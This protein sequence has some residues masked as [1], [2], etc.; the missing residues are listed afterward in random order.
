MD[1]H[2][3]ETIRLIVES[4]SDLTPELQKAANF[5]LENPEEV[6]LNSMRSVAK[7]ARVKPATVSRLS[8]TLGFDEYDRFREPFRQ[9]LRRNEPTFARG[10]AEVQRRGAGSSEAL[11]SELREQELMNVEEAPTRPPSCFTMPTSCSRRTV[12]SSIRAQEYSRIS[13]E[14]LA[15]RTVSS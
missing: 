10:V 15:S 8:K 5:I 2:Y 4:F 1:R 7:G 3:S 9:R 13:Y 14:G 6:G 11:F 12:F